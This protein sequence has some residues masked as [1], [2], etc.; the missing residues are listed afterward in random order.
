MVKPCIPRSRS[1]ALV[2]P[3]LLLCIAGLCSAC[4]KPLPKGWTPFQLALWNPIQVFVEE[5][6]VRGARVG[7]YGSN[8]DMYGI[9]FGFI[10]LSESMTGIQVNAGY[11]ESENLDGIQISAVN[12]VTRRMRGLQLGGVMSHA[13]EVLGMQ[14]AGAH[15]RAETVVG[16]QFGAM[17]NETEELA[18]VQIGIVNCN[19]S[20]R[21]PFQCIPVFS[22]G[23]GGVSEEDEDTED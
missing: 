13:D 20:R 11:S 9:D 16:L 21:T 14:I 15:N 2:V 4:M 18:G 1:R 5:D 3:V 12:E 19:W 6:G 7:L 23:F 22:V 17:V 10:G 8:T